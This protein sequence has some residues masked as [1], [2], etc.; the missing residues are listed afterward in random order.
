MK[1]HLIL[2][3]VLAAFVPAQTALAAAQKVVDAPVAQTSHTAAG[4]KVANSRQLSAEER[5][6]LRRQLYQYRLQGKG[7]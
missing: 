5:A 4:P 7:S 2:T 6:E 1:R 3:A